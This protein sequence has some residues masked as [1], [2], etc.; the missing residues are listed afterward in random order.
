MS[1]VAG[2]GRVVRWIGFILTAV[3]GL[4]GGLFAAGYAFEDPGGPAAV[5]M[6]LA[7]LVPMVGLAV[8]ALLRPGPAAPV[9]IVL[10]LVVGLFSVLDPAVGL[11][12]RDSWGPVGTV[13]MLP[14]AVGLAALGLHRARLGGVLLVTLAVLQFLGLLFPFAGARGGGE[15][16]GMGALLAG[17]SGVLVLPLLIAGLLFLVSS[18]LSPEVEQRTIRP[19]VRAAH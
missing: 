7:W 15:G 5:A 4:L 17:S 2:S 18:W 3:F 6:L 14:V 10:T 12:P 16:P 9:M 1:A 19:V 13:A 8:F 11:V